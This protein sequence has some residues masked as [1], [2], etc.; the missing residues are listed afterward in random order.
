ME[1]IAEARIGSGLSIELQKRVTIGVELAAKPALMIFLDEPTVSFSDAGSVAD[2][3]SGLDGQGA[4]NLVRL[5]RKLAGQGMSILATI[6][7]PS[8][9]LV[10]TAVSITIADMQFQQFDEVLLLGPGGRTIYFG[11]I[12]KDAKTL[13]GYF[14]SHKYVESTC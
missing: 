3:Q 8:S 1:D 5:L 12:G 4:W 6:H 13:T 11:E 2:F 14:E 9:E 10:S 7:Q